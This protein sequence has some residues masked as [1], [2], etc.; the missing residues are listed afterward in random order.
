MKILLII[1]VAFLFFVLG[2]GKKESDSAVFIDDIDDV[3]KRYEIVGFADKDGK[4]VRSLQCEKMLKSLF[5]AAACFDEEKIYE[6]VVNSSQR[7]KEREKF[8]VHTRIKECKSRGNVRRFMVFDR[9]KPFYVDFVAVIDEKKR[10]KIKKLKNI[11]VEVY[12]ADSRKNNFVIPVAKRC[13]IHNENDICIK[14]E[15]I[16]LLNRE[17]LHKAVKICR[18]FSECGVKEKQNIKNAI[19]EEFLLMTLNEINTEREVIKYFLKNTQC[20][21]ALSCILGCVCLA[22]DVMLKGM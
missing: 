8:C 10:K 9:D 16:R 22:A 1:C 4:K 21:L 6:A 2:R 12:A 20:F 13:A 14:G 19:K 7:L 15:E 17:E 11:G 18:L 3:I 5:S